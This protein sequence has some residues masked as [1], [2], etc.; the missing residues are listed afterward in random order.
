MTLEKRE[1]S[2]GS[3]D[4]QE[5]RQPELPGVPLS[6]GE[7]QEGAVA[8][9][10]STEAQTPHPTMSE[11]LLAEYDYERPKRGDIRKGIIVSMQPSEIVVDIGAKRECI[12]AN[13]DYQKLLSEAA[14]ELHAGDEVSVYIIKPE[15]RDG[16]LLGSLYLAQM[17]GD[18][19]RAEALEASGE[20]FEAR[21]S[22]QNRGGLLVP[23]GR[24]RGF[25][26]A[27][28][29]VG[30]SSRDGDQ[31][32]ALTHWIG[33]TLPFK[34]IEVNRR[35]NRLILSYR[36]ARRQWRP[37]QR[38][39]LLETLHEGDT[40]KGIVSSLAS[41][42]AFVDLGGADGLI[43]I[44]ELAWYRVEHPSDLL[45]VG[46]EIEVY[47]LRVDPSRGRVGL[48]LKRLQPDPWTMVEGKYAPGQVVEVRITKLVD[49]GAFAEVEKGIEGL[50]HASELADPAPARV[51]D[52]VQPGEVH[53][54]K[55]LRVDAE[56][57]R[58]GLSLRAVTPEEQAARQG[59]APEAP[60]PA[61][62]G[63]NTI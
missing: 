30:P 52:A 54:A 44:S 4:L 17:E 61:T 36:A 53:L 37:Q 28:H 29:L 13:S 14:G 49:F 6:V 19:A 21:V 38:E 11:A 39:S 15:D 63:E 40:R 23:F 34:V 55:V 16:H 9:G 58:I 33:K 35:R 26:P 7:E 48:S 24:L 45:K 50:I 60:G 22:G 51:G 43:H 46:Q 56:N 27:S 57:R 59:E 20:I 41:F 1:G 5:A 3:T 62:P 42:G 25:V 10:A 32:V 12:I 47:V 8:Q 31:P 18:W 2:S